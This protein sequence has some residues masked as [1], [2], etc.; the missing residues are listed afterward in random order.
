MQK[1]NLN[2]ILMKINFDKLIRKNLFKIKVD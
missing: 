2:K 1:R